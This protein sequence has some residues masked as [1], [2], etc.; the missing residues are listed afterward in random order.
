[1]GWKGLFGGAKTNNMFS[2][3]D[4]I[5]FK[6]YLKTAS[7]GNVRA[8]RSIEIPDRMR[9]YCKKCDATYTYNLNLGKLTELP[10]DAQ[11][12]VKFHRHAGNYQTHV[13]SL[14]EKAAQAEAKA[15][16]AEADQK[17]LNE[18]LQ[19]YQAEY[20]EKKAKLEEIVKNIANPT[21]I[22]KPE[23][24]IEPIIQTAPGKFAPASYQ[25]YASLSNI[26][27]SPDAQQAANLYA[28][29]LQAKI[30]QSEMELQ[31]AKMKL[32]SIPKIENHEQP[33]PQPKAPK[34][35]EGRKFR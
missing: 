1:M 35:P 17:I 19:K 25:D 9:L 32:N 12:F 16:K 26:V 3:T 21:Y 5:Y 30:Q 4:E 18:Q 22:K 29:N 31:L 23:D 6:Q 10:H 24:G 27:L 2:S 15:A 34:T 7:D 33:K 20:A 11:D 13:G 8:D 14:E 28:A